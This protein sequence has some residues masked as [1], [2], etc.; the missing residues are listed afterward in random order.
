[1]ERAYA[2]EEELRQVCDGYFSACD[3]A[4]LFYGEAGLALHLGVKLDTLRDWYDGKRRPELQE[5]VQRAYL[6][7][8]SQLE[9][10]P[11]YV[12]KGMVTK[13]I[14]LLRQPRLGG[15]QDKAETRQDAAV[16]VRMGGSMDESDFQ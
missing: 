11:A 13:S 9:S 8:Q 3:E 2:S 5:E 14:F 1:M 7:I 6:R 16:H 10:S 15:Y 12:G 4:E